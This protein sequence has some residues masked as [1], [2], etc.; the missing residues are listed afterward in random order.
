[1]IQS[2]SEKPK[3]VIGTPQRSL[4]QRL[5][6]RA[7]RTSVYNLYEEAKVRGVSLQRK[8]WVQVLFECT[9]YAILLAFIYLVLVG[10]PLW[11]GAVYWL[12]WVVKNKFAIEGGW[13][14]VL[15]LSTM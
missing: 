2:K 10:L 8:Y 1:L 11:N 5:A 15:G 13:A 3:E 9:V 7:Q 12:Y 6:N 14:I 4:S